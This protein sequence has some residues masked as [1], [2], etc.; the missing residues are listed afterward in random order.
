MGVF[1]QAVLI[2]VVVLGTSCGLFLDQEMIY[3]KS[4]QNR[5]T[6]QD[7]RDR[8]GPPPWTVPRSAGETTWVYQMTQREKGGNNILDIVG[9]WCDEYVLTFDQSGVLR[10]WENKSQKHRD[11]PS[12]ATC[13]TNGFMSKASAVHLE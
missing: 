6:H 9:Y 2:S 4:A 1:I 12:P 13:V 8:L 7:V 3:L 5:A 10:H 11:P